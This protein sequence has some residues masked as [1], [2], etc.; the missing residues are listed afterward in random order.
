MKVFV[1]YDPQQHEAYQVCKYSIL[2]HCKTATVVPLVQAQLKQ[3]GLYWRKP[4]PLASTEFTYTRFLVPKLQSYSGWALFMDL[5]F[6]WLSSVEEVFALKDPQYAVQ[7][8]KHLHQPSNNTKMNNQPQTSYPKKNWSSL[9]LWNCNY[10]KNC[11]TAKQVSENPASW[12]HQ[13]QW[14]QDHEIGSL[15][16]AYNHLV[17]YS[18]ADPKALHYT[19]GGPW[20][21]NYPNSPHN[22]LW[23]NYK[24]EMLSQQN[25]YQNLK[26]D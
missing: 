22:K 9:V 13:F 7:V 3:L 10:P 11:I 17:G 2:K 18:N 12:L 5:D 4:D 8:V 14:L 19:D 23:I 26:H 15:P 25:T 16:E 6:L 24:Q 21:K 1:G 20:F